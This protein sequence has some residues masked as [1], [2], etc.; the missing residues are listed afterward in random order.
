MVMCMV[1]RVAVMVG[2]V[3]GSA[4]SVV[5]R[6]QAP[7]GA[8]SPAPAQRMAY[9]NS[10]VIFEAVPGRA[11]AQAQFEKEMTATRGTVQKLQDSLQALQAAYGK[12]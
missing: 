8:P 5:V 9:V 7:A 12:E 2:L 11:D 6:A 3:A 4:A 1:R 10:Q